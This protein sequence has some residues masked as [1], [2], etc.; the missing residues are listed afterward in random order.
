MV[1]AVDLTVRVASILEDLGIRYVVGGSIA[2]ILHGE[3][4]FTQDSDILADIPESRVTALVAALSGEFFIQESSV[5]DAVTRRG[6]FNALHLS[7]T[8]KIDFYL[9]GRNPLDAAQLSRA[10]DARFERYSDRTI[11]VTSPEDIVVRKLDW[12]RSGRMVSDRQWRDV[13]GVLKVGG[14]KLDLAY[15]KE[16]ALRVGLDELLQRALTESG[17]GN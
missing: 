17:L 7:S 11:K 2:S 5:R 6:S 16:T 4:R 14:R 3:P 15:M 12:Y 13:L 1:D 8:L 10:I 9:P